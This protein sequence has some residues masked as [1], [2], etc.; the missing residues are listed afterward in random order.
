[1]HIFILS[2]IVVSPHRDTAAQG[3]VEMRTKSF[4]QRY[5][6]N[7][8]LF[9]LTDHGLVVVRRWRPE[10]PPALPRLRAVRLAPRERLGVLAQVDAVDGGRRG[11]RATRGG[12]R[13]ARGRRAQARRRLLLLLLHDHAARRRRRR[14]RR[15]AE[16]GDLVRRSGKGRR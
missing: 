14:G 2:N 16:V 11:V 3:K 4:I 13:Q 8:F 6:V 15:R 12:Q 7:E 9:I 1:M 5:S 10:G